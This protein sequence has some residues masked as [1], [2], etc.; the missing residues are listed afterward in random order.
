MSPV[1][2]ESWSQSPSATHPNERHG[3]RQLLRFSSGIDFNRSA[4]TSCVPNRNVQID[5][6][7]FGVAHP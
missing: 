5:E 4:K 3:N 7:S 2:D 6:R 1:R